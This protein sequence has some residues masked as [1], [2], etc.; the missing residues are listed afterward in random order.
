MTDEAPLVVTPSM[1]KE[2]LEHSETLENITQDSW[3]GEK[4][5]GRRENDREG[6][7]RGDAVHAKEGSRTHRNTL[8][9]WKD[10]RLD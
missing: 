9:H 6:A 3:W 2:G 7:V 8:E 1:R 10:S 5:V 4:A